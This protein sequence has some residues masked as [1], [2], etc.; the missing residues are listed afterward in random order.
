VNAGAVLDPRAAID[1]AAEIGPDAFIGPYCVIGPQVVI[2]RGCR[3][4]SHVVVAGPTEIGPENQISPM[5]SI[6]GPPQDNKYRGEPTCLRIG[7]RNRIREFVTLNRGTAGGGGVTVV[8]D[9]NLLM[10]YAHV[11][12]DC[13]VGHRTIFA[14]AATLAGHVEVGDDAT[15]G[16]FSAV[17]QF[18]RVADHAFIGGYSVVTRDALPWVL[19]VGNR[20]RARGLNSVGLQRRGY[21]PEVVEAL[22]RCYTL[23]FRSKLLLE[24]ALVQVE[25]E[26]GHVAEVRYFVEFVRGSRRG[27]CR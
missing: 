17:H 2:G 5:A 27:V 9:D 15:I 25:R 1:P 16:A 11:A 7:A 26:L 4:E 13:R 22:K 14:N 8:G 19:T 6:G 21:A 23:L 18:C 20:A 3:L 24:Q 10:A 12:H